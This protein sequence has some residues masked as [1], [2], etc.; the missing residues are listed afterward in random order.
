[1]SC[2]TCGINDNIS[3]VSFLAPRIFD[4]VRMDLDRRRL[5]MTVQ[6]ALPDIT[7]LYAGSTGKISAG[8]TL[9][10]IPQFNADF[11]AVSG[12]LELPAVL[13]YVY[14]GN[15]GTAPATLYVPVSMQMNTPQS[16]AWPF[17]LT[18]HYSF[19][20]DNIASGENGSYST[21][22]DGIIMVYVTSEMPI[23]VKS[24]GQLNT[25]SIVS[26][27]VINQSEYLTSA[28]YPAFL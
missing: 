28:F 10:I 27:E 6:T 14:Q 15:N 22:A 23:T 7:P 2:S 26:R 16:T 1:M 18:V 21:L 11:S 8:S 24:A 20:A 19:F 12:T 17:D 5:A 4:N 9:S 3:T 13:T 25:N